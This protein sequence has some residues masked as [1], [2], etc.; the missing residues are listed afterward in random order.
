M[1]TETIRLCEQMSGVSP[2]QSIKTLDISTI[3]EPRNSTRS[4]AIW[5]G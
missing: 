2:P 4:G 1:K 3:L 5:Y